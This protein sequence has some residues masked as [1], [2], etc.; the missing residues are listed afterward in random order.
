MDEL[1][2]AIFVIGL[3]IAVIVAAVTAVLLL[4]LHTFLFS[5]AAVGHPLI[6]LLLVMGIVSLARVSS[7]AFS[8]SPHA[9][10]FGRLMP[11]R[12]WTQIA[13]IAFMAAIGF[14]GVLVL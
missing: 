2:G 5:A 12:S 3:T 9:M 1:F 13:T 14:Y 11:V 8:S 10:L 7:S 6:L 4:L